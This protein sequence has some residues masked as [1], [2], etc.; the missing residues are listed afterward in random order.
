MF[1]RCVYF[2]LT[3]LTRKVTK[4]WQTEFGRLDLSPSH[5]YLLKAMSDEP[6]ASQKDL[7]AAMELDA[8]TVTRF[9]DALA[10]RGLIEKLSVGKGARYRVS[11]LGRRT[12]KRIDRLMDELYAQMQDTFGPKVLRDFVSQVQHARH[13]FEP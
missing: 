9:I 5:G 4:L 1:D 6:D 8:S 3:T 7:S 11:P 13:H 10:Q 2:N 12:V